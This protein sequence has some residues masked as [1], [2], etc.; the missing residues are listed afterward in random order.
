MTRSQSV[1]RCQQRQI[2]QGWR[3]LN[4]RLPPDAAQALARMEEATGLTPTAILTGLLTR[5]PRR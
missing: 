4:L 1:A 5:R 2:E 3:R